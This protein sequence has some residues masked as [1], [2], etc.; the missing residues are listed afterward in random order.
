M[1][2]YIPFLI[3]KFK[4]SKLFSTLIWFILCI[5]ELVY[6]IAHRKT[7]PRAIFLFAHPGAIELVVNNL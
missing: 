1:K 2:E 4:K 7:V 5:L 3:S 6:Q